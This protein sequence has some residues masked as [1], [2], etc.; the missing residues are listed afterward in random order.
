MAS[1]IVNECHVKQESFM[2][3][4]HLENIF[5]SSGREVIFTPKVL[6]SDEPVNGNTLPEIRQGSQHGETGRLQG[7]KQQ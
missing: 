1:R 7:T 2:V 3:T 5:Q 4:F 6:K